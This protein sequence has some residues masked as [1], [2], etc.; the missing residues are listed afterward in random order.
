PHPDE[1]PPGAPPPDAPLEED[2]R[3]WML[4]VGLFGGFVGIRPDYLDIGDATFQSS[5]GETLS[6]DATTCTTNLHVPQNGGA[7][8][9]SVFAGYQLT[10]DFH[11]GGRALVGPRI[12]G[13]LVGGLGPAGAMRVV[14]PLWLG[15]GALIGGGSFVATGT[16]S[17]PE[18]GATDSEIGGTVGVGAGPLLDVTAQLVDT[19]QGAFGLSLLPFFLIGFDGG[20]V[21]SVPL[22]VFFRFQ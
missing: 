16:V 11:L 5:M 1:P 6:C 2:R 22:T 13:G 21:Y 20:T 15:L 12:G 17:S 14:G 19:D 10:P 3:R 4:E 9:L 7:V 8:G 18:L